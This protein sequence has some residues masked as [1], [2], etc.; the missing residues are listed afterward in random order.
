MDEFVAQNMAHLAELTRV[1]DE[2][3]AAVRQG[4]TPE[5]SFRNTAYMLDEMDP[6]I[7]MVTIITRPNETSSW[8]PPDESPPAAVYAAL[9]AAGF[10]EEAENGFTI[11]RPRADVSLLL[12]SWGMAEVAMEDFM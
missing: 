9:I 8:L 2:A 6:S 10:S 7:T 12:S 4:R 5:H 3:V 11:E 1:F